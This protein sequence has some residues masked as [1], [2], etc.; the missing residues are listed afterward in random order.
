MERAG[1]E[2]CDL[3]VFSTALYLT[4]LS[5]LLDRLGLQLF[6]GLEGSTRAGLDVPTVSDPGEPTRTD[7]QIRTD[8]LGLEARR[9]TINTTSA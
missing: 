2:P 1:F 4:E 9:A 6:P 8:A 3:C 7:D 5:L